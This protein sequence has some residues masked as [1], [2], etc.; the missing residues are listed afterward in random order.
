MVVTVKGA[1]VT[2][3]LEVEREGKTSD[4]G[5]DCEGSKGVIL[6]ADEEQ[7]QEVRSPL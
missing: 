2:Y 4:H 1:G 6:P 5:C 3:F 7:W